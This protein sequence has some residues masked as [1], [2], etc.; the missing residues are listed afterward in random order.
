M[1]NN[2]MVKTFKDY[3][4]ESKRTYPFKIK[5]AGDFTTE[6]EATLKSLL[7]KY[8]IVEFKKLATT[9]VQLLPLDFPRFQNTQVN[10]WEVALNYPIAPH[11]LTNYLGN[12]L[13]ILE[14]TIVVRNPGDPLEE[15][16]KPHVTR[17][18][19]LLTDPNYTEAP[20]AKFK[21]FYGTEYNQSLVK[22]LNNTLKANRE[23]RG[24]KIP[25][26]GVAE[27]IA[28]LP[29]NNVSPIAKSIKGPVSKTRN[30]K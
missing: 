12:G 22:D 30:G 26:A 16:Q 9:P 27:T 7:E 3:L 4:I 5:I 20:N 2:N 23:A 13:R 6:Q 25:S 1:L 24:E 29:Q 10:I 28:D 17:E 18:G 11:E 15:Y 21:D 14:Q 8:K 19:A